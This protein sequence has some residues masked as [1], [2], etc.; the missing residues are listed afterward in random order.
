MELQTLQ[1]FYTFTKG[2]TYILIVAAL[3]G[4]IGFWRFLTDRDEKKYE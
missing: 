4:F 3:I 2:V 1:E